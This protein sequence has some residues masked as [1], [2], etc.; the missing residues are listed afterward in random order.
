MKNLF[1]LTY[2]FSLYPGVWNASGKI[3]L[4][5]SLGL[6]GIG[7]IIRAFA[8]FTHMEIIW[9]RMMEKLSS[10]LFIYGVLAVLYWFMRDQGVPFFSSRFWL[11]LMVITAAIWLYFIVKYLLRKLY[12]V[13]HT[14]ESLDLY[15]KYLPGKKT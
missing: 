10:W 4:F 7:T 14:K 3:F 12:E 11:L 15:A 1:T 9:K 6:I 13:K 2:W 8:M 5:I